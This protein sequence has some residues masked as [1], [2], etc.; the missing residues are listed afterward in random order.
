MP[1]VSFFNRL[2]HGNFCSRLQDE[3]LEEIKYSMWS[4]FPPAPLLAM[5][6]DLFRAL[7]SCLIA[8]HSLHYLD[9]LLRTSDHRPKRFPR[10]PSATAGKPNAFSRAGGGYPAGMENNKL[11]KSGSR[12]G[13]WRENSATLLVANVPTARG[14]A[15][16]M[17]VIIIRAIIVRRSCVVT[18]HPLPV[19]S[20]I[21]AINY[22]L[23]NSQTVFS[24]PFI[25]SVFPR[26]ALWECPSVSYLPSHFPPCDLRMPCAETDQS[27]MSV[28]EHPTTKGGYHRHLSQSKGLPLKLI[29]SS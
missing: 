12:E 7:P 27:A 11:P 20:Q 16:I 25:C 9:S 4:S 21:R 26:W 17:R 2:Y 3:V 13:S 19:K 29:N 1:S 8:W 5:L 23:F 15:V 18:R 22:I 14:H 28:L 10:K 6:C 24:Y